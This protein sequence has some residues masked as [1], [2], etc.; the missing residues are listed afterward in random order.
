MKKLWAEAESQALAKARKDGVVVYER[1]QL[2]IGGIE[3][4]AVK[5]YSK[6][7]TNPQD[8]ATVLGILRSE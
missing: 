7:V 6:Y 1:H 8:M 4:Y 5:L 3:T 2:G